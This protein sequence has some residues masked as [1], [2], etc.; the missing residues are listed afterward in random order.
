M[1]ACVNCKRLGECHIVDEQK[2]LNNYCCGDW[3]EVHQAEVAARQQILFKFGSAG[4]SV[5]LNKP[6]DRGE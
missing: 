6:A 4:I 5:L 1:F 3:R 2:L